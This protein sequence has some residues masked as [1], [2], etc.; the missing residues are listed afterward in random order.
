MKAAKQ[1][2]QQL[3][4]GAVHAQLL[5]SGAAEVEIEGETIRLE[6]ED[7]EVAVVAAEHFAAAGDSSTVVVLNTALD[8][9]L[10]DEGLYREVLRRVQDFRKDLDVAYTERIQLAVSGSDRIERIVR[11]NREHLAGETL[12][13]EVSVGRDGL[14]QAE[15][16]ETAVDGEDLRL[17]LQ[18]G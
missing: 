9:Q 17:E 2:F 15:V 3:D 18:R 13:S 5:A 7:I 4:A 1:A 11:S 16:R 14:P 8:E 10:E 12:C 6:P